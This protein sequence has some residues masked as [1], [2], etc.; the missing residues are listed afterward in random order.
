MNAIIPKVV[1]QYLAQNLGDR[2]SLVDETFAIQGQGLEHDRYSEGRGSWNKNN[3]GKRQVSV[4]DIGVF[5][6]A[7]RGLAIPFVPADTRRNILTEG[8]DLASL[9]NVYFMIGPVLMMGRKI[10]KPCPRPSKLSG[11]KDFHIAFA[12]IKAGILAD[13]LS[14]GPI[15]THDIIVPGCFICGRIPE[16]VPYGRRCLRCGT[17]MNPPR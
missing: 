11:K 16:K 10:C 3:L 12:G 1:G 8:V 4:I 14:S 7:N 6:E 15:K 5:E 2:M 9:L 13:V 17:D